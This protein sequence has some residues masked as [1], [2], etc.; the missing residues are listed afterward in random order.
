MGSPYSI[1]L[2]VHLDLYLV[3]VDVNRIPIVKLQITGVAPGG[4]LEKT[5]HVH[6]KIL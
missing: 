5:G 3:G 2:L 1:L 4:F 6:I